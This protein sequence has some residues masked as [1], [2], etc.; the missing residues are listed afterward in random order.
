MRSRRR[1]AIL[2]SGRGSNMRALVEAAQAPDYPAES[3]RVLSNRPEAAGL[4]W[5]RDAGVAVAAVD[6]NIHARREELER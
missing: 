6:H 3:A 2:I 1:T 4:S 5:A